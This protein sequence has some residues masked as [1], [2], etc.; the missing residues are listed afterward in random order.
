MYIVFEDVNFNICKYDLNDTVFICNN[1]CYVYNKN[2]LINVKKYISD[3]DDMTTEL[4]YMYKYK[5]DSYNDYY[6]NINNIKGIIHNK[7]FLTDHF[8]LRFNDDN[9]ICNIKQYI[10]NY[11]LLQIINNTE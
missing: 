5:M 1:P 10:R 7:L 9:D 4:D 3:L 6:F 8:Y 2:A 11:K